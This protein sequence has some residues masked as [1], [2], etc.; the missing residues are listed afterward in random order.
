MR[1]YLVRHGETVWNLEGRFQGFS[2]KELSP[3]GEEQAREVGE[4]LKDIPFDAVYSSSLIRAKRTAELAVENRGLSVT[5][6][7]AFKE[8]NLGELEGLQEEQILQSY[9]GV[10]QQLR[11]DPATYIPPGGENLQDVQD[12]AWPAL[13][14]LAK[15]HQGETVLLVAHHSVNKSLICKMLST[16]LTSFKIIRQPPCTISVLEITDTHKFVHAVNLNWGEKVSPWHDLEDEVKDLISEPKAVIFDMDGVILDSMS[17]YNSAWRHALA[18]RGIFPSEMEI[19]RHEGEKGAESIKQFFAQAGM[20]CSSLDVIEILDRVYEIYYR[21]PKV[22]PF[23]DAFPFIR[24]LK[25]RGIKTAIVTGSKRFD[26]NGRLS[27]E[28]QGLFDTIITQDD[29]DNGKPHPEPYLKALDNLGLKASE[30][31]VIENAPFGIKAAK[32]AGL[33]TIAITT[34]LPREELMGADLVIDSL[35]RVK[36]W[37]GV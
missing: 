32:T 18:E 22:K 8:H 29:V 12:R 23:S 36:G 15:K 3:R 4:Q 20:E 25:E 9:P 6:I 24:G 7:D 27:S 30:A 26:I 1:L 37:V 33:L 11:D 10:L 31:F 17:H 13:I 34:T 21:Y 28:E 5:P 35:T 19:Y 16:P 14:E 2:D